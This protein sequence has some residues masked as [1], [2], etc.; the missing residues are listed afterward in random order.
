MGNYPTVQ[1]TVGTE[2]LLATETLLPCYSSNAGR[3]VW[4]FLPPPP[5]LSVPLCKTLSLLTSLTT[6]GLI[7]WHVSIFLRISSLLWTNPLSDM[8]VPL[9]SPPTSSSRVVPSGREWWESLSSS[10]LLVVNS[11]M[12]V[13]LWYLRR[14]TGGGGKQ[15]RR[16]GREGV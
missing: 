3:R 5:P 10:K 9:P 12:E 14:S 7:C 8:D 16:R 1:S 13:I 4:G 15:G 6:S 2:L 11:G